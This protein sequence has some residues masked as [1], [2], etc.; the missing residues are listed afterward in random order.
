MPKP[1]LYFALYP[2]FR[3]RSIPGYLYITPTGFLIIPPE[4]SEQVLCV[5]FIR[6][7]YLL[8]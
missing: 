7:G 6:H 3:Y 2:A 1:V 5:E 8:C 4:K